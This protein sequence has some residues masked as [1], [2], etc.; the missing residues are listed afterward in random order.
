MRNLSYENEF[1]FSSGDSATLVNRHALLR[2][3]NGDFFKH[4]DDELPERPAFFYIPG[5]REPKYDSD[6]AKMRH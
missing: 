4:T 6:N 3:S 5:N 2:P 1:C